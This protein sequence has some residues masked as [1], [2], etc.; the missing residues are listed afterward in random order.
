MS[1]TRTHPEAGAPPA[2]PERPGWGDRTWQRGERAVGALR[3]RWRWFDHLARAGGRY[4]RHQGDLLAAGVT[5]FTFLGLFPVLLL[6]ASVIGLVLAGDALLQRELYDAIGEAFP[7]ATGEGIV[8]ELRGAVGVAGV[9]GVIG[10][11]GFVYAGLRA[12]DKLRIGMEQIWKGRVD[13]PEFWRDNLQDLLALVLLGA[14]ALLSLALTGVA[15][16]ASTWTLDLLGLGDVGGLA[17]L[18]TVVGLL[19]AF[20]TDVVVFLWLLKVVPRTTHRLPALLP[21]ALFGAAGF[22]VM[23][24]LGSFYLSL[25]D[26]SVTASALGGA[27]GI[28]V[29]INIVF[30]FAFFTAAWTATLPPAAPARE[31]RPAEPLLEEDPPSG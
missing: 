23:K 11:V 2:A 3:A 17:L 24:L 19:L 15:T 16:L 18:T 29:W 21:G 10:L 14:V 28:L 7:G 22:E 13:E 8:D 25:I 27:V 20:L 6:A 5:Y 4:Q 12:M 31:D 1:A 30:R 9:V 26:E